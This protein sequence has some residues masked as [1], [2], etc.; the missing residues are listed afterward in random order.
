MEYQAYIDSPEW[1]VKADRTRARACGQCECCG[2]PSRRLEVHHLTYIR[3]KR[4]HVTD[5]VALCWTCHRKA[6]HYRKLI[7]AIET[8]AAQKGA[9][10]EWS[11]ERFIR[12]VVGDLMAWIL[13]K[14]PRQ[15][16]T[17]RRHKGGS[18]SRR[19]IQR[20]NGRV[21]SGRY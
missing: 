18:R 11:Y 13:D 4:E 20:R 17:K 6:D 8:H 21:G 15:K 5:L 12:D 9:W 1:R 19:P 14:K 10:W 7:K 16:S 2:R 3:F